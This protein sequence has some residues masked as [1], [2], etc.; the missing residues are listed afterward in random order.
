M[1]EV[2]PTA[3]R[4]LAFAGLTLAFFSVTETWRTIEA[5]HG[6]VLADGP[7]R[8]WALTVGAYLPGAAVL[9]FLRP[10]DPNDSTGQLRCLRLLAAGAMLAASAWRWRMLVG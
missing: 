7:R 8:T 2:Q 6:F 4:L 5:D 9:C 1:Y 3:L 10:I